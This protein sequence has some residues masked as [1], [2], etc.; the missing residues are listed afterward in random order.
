[1]T[2]NEDD[3]VRSSLNHHSTGCAVESKSD[4][5]PLCCSAAAPV[6]RLPLQ[7]VA[8]EGR[9]TPAHLLL[10]PF[11]L[12]NAHNY[13]QI[14]ASPVPP[15]AA[16]YNRA[17]SLPP[18]YLPCLASNL[19]LFCVCLQAAIYNRAQAKKTQGKVGL[20]QVRGSKT[21]RRVVGWF[22][23]WAIDGL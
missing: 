10:L 2:F 4:M 14:M 15:Q 1:M 16:I 21:A 19:P 22:R 9:S 23:L 3:Q 18:S 7:P 20:G 13:S 8:A 6:C 12:P 11:C 5:A 17:R